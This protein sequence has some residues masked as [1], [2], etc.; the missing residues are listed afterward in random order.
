MFPRKGH[1]SMSWRNLACRTR[2]HRLAARQMS[3]QSAIE[4]ALCTPILLFTL[5]GAGDIARRF[6]ADVA[7]TNA[8]RE[9]A[10]WGS[11]HSCAVEGVVAKVRSAFGPASIGSDPRQIQAVRVTTDPAANPSGAPLC[12]VTVTYSFSLVS[13][14]PTGSMTLTLQARAAMLLR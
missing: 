1:C 8:A 13:P 11:L 9:G 12:R 7:L 6:A 4:L 14:I 3:G 5:L 10:Y 2:P